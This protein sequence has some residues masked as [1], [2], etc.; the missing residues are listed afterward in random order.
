MGD[1]ATVRIP[2]GTADRS[3]GDGGPAPF[4]RGVP[5]V[6]IA[7]PSDAALAR[8]VQRGDAA[9][10]DLLVQRHMKRAF[11]VAYRL[12]GHAEDSE[13]LVQEAFIAALQKID[14]FD[15]T[16][17]FA[18]WFYRILV[19]RCLNARKARTRRAVSELPVDVASG[20]ASPLVEA[21]RSELRDQLRHALEKLPERQRSIVALFDIEGFSSPEIAAMLEITDGTV[22]W[23]LHQ[24][25]RTL[26]EV[27]EPHVRR[28][29]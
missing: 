20:L 7:D 18:P 14:T 29:V 22:R 2:T 26:R 23:H 10:F 19:N 5:A 4:G 21:E 17:D 28:Q 9:A 12:L 16:R 15:A 13:D 3:M 1:A 24:A 27:L 6:S 8:R 25:R 11:G